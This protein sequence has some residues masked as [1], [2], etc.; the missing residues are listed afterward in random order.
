MMP[1]S[2]VASTSSAP[3]PGLRFS[4][5][6][7]PS[8]TL[9]RE[10]DFSAPTGARVSPCPY[11]AHNPLIPG[12]VCRGP[13]ATPKLGGSRRRLGDARIQARLHQRRK[14]LNTIARVP[15]AGRGT[16][17]AGAGPLSPHRPFWP[18]MSSRLPHTPQRPQS[19]GHVLRARG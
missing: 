17:P 19:G 5:A 3:S 1:G 8:L 2:D 12:L 11:A 18:A 10:P 6:L 15:L 7:W 14:W 16:A 13:M 4:L 9:T